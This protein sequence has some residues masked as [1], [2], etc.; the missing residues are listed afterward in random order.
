MSDHIASNDGMSI[1]PAIS[2]LRYRVR[3][4]ENRVLSRIFE[5]KG[6]ALAG[7]GLVAH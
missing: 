4:F 2:E 7:G 1:V 5:P 3:P 6:L